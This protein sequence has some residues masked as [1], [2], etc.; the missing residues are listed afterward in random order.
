MTEIRLRAD[1][2][3]MYRTAVGCR[4][5]LLRAGVDRL[6]VTQADRPDPAPKCALEAGD[7][8]GAECSPRFRAADGVWRQ[9]MAG[10]GK[11]AV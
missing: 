6:V 3:K 9:F 5:D 7:L 2:W 8:V 1:I 10:C 4:A 11:K